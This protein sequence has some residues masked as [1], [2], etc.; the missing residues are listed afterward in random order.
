VRRLDFR[1]DF[2]VKPE[3][4]EADVAKTLVLYEKKYER[5]V[6][7]KCALSLLDI[8]LTQTPKYLHKWKS[9]LYRSV[10]S[11]RNII[12]T[13]LT[14]Y[15]AVLGNIISATIQTLALEKHLSYK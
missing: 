14:G 8:P 7:I 9:E 6:C 13:L 1:I 15:I 4:A 11:A 3:K 5:R 12:Q 2:G 10:S